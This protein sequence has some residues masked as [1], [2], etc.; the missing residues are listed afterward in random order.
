[1][2]GTGIKIVNLK[3]IEVDKKLYPRNN[4]YWYN[5]FKYEQAMKSGAKF[6]P[7]VLA[8]YK[9]KLILVD[10]LHRLEATRKLGKTAIDAKILKGLT[11][12]EIFI[13]AVRLNIKHGQPLCASEI[14]NIILKFEKYGLSP[15]QISDVISMPMEKIEPFTAART[16]RNSLTGEIITLKK[17]L[18]YLVKEGEVISD[19]KFTALSMGNTL[20]GHRQDKLFED[21]IYMFENRLIEKTTNVKRLMIKLKKLITH[22]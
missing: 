17:P 1:M 11:E 22:Y 16:I 9:G 3:D 15:I 4:S 12:K 19:E 2:R 6:P 5:A 13:E 20:I 18:K 7:I 10:G 14:N 21:L 8:D